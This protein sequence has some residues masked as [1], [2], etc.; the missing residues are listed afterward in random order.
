VIDLQEEYNCIPNDDQAN[1][2]DSLPTV[3]R[4]LFVRTTYHHITVFQDGK[5]CGVLSQNDVVE[6]LA[7][8]PELLGQKKECPVPK[9]GLLSA[10]VLSVTEDDTVLAG[11][12]LAKKSDKREVAVVDGDGK[13]VGSINATALRGLT[14][15]G[16]LQLP[17][18]EYKEK[19]K[20][21]A[22]VAVSLKAT[23]KDVV[24]AVGPSRSLRAYAVDEQG[25][26]LFWMTLN[27]ILR[28]IVNSGW[29]LNNVTAA[30]VC[31]LAH[32]GLQVQTLSEDN[33]LGDALKHLAENNLLT[34]PVLRNGQYIGMVDVMDILGEL[35]TC[36]EDRQRGTLRENEHPAGTYQYAIADKEVFA[37]V[38][39]RGLS[40][41]KYTAKDIVE[42]TTTLHDA[43]LNVFLP[44]RY[45]RISVLNKGNVVNVLSQ[46]D[47][48][49]F[50]SRYPD[51][52]GDRG[53]STIEELGFM[54]RRVRT[55]SHRDTMMKAFQIMY[56]SSSRA[57]AVVNGKGRLVTNVHAGDLKGLSSFYHLRLMI[58]FAKSQVESPED[59]PSDAIPLPMPLTCTKDETLS[60]VVHN[61]ML[62]GHRRAYIIDPEGHPVSEVTLSDIFKSLIKPGVDRLFSSK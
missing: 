10:E 34:A 27:E 21:P 62:H 11:L 16:E 12:M 32:G 22:P 56:H 36:L 1:M 33:T 6:Y 8:Q 28:A 2:T 31:K 5:A 29:E 57:V 4:H 59:Y 60:S 14:D 38:S 46:R 13:L 18:K 51:I 55:V 43:I 53:Q 48:A 44:Y 19:H 37:E 30:D 17:I 39:A 52:L 26:P 58:C 7:E 35:I 61:M 9:L 45:H 41:L 50:I 15:L 40:T 47:I 23:L 49:K 24:A 25:K 20:V 3:L 42:E 54:K